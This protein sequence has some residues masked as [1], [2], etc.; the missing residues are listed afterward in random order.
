MIPLFFLNVTTVYPED[1]PLA[2]YLL[3]YVP[4]WE[5]DPDLQ[6]DH[7]AGQHGEMHMRNFATLQT[8]NPSEGVRFWSAKP[9]VL[10]PSCGWD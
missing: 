6:S 9:Q 2:V 1:E 4:I 8:E 7:S 5:A 3:L 10:P